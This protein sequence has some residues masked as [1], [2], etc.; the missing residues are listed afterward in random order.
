V[1]K[2]YLFEGPR[3]KETLRELFDGRSQLIV[4]HFMFNPSWDE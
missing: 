3:G 2:E 4:Y 1:N